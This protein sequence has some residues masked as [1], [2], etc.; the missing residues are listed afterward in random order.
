MIHDHFSR[1]GL[2]MHVGKSTEGKIKASKTECVFFQRHNSLTTISHPEK[3]IL[4]GIM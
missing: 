2:E 4:K 3:K 1:F